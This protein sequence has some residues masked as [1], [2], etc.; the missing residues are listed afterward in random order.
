MILDSC[1]DVEKNV[2]VN[3]A[4][5]T[6]E[7]LVLEHCEAPLGPQPRALKTGRE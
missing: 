7:N 4:S 6:Q 2:S 1:L 5:G 3:V